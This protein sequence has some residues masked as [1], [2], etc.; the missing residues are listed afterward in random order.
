MLRSLASGFALLLLAPAQ[1][2]AVQSTLPSYTRA[3]QL[4]R[5]ADTSANVSIGDVNND[6]KPDLVL[7]KGRHWP[8][9]S[10]VM[11]GDGRGH[12]PTAYDLS[13][14]RYRS[15]SGNLVDING[16]G[17]LDVILS[18]DAPDPKVILRNDGTG[19]FRSI[20]TF[21]MANWPTRNVAI[22]DLNGD[23]LPDI[24]VANRAQRA[25]EYIC[26]NHQ[27]NFDQPCQPFADYSATT[28]TPADVDGDGRVDLVVPHRDGGQ[29][30][31]YVN[32]GNASFPASRRIPFGPP[33][34]TIR[35]AVVSDLDDDG[36]LDI[37]AIDDTHGATRIYYGLGGGFAAAVPLGDGKSV[38]YAL[39]VTDLNRDRHPDVLVGFVR[40]RSIA[41]FGAGKARTFS[42]VAFGDDRGS[43]YGFASADLD[44]DGCI[45]IAA[46]R[47]EAP[48]MVYF[49]EAV[50]SPPR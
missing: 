22:A 32:D 35:M 25:T 8:G 13:D 16:D 14:T 24:V 45:D 46:A 23:R 43:V 20:S 5:G 15:Y 21:G 12:F 47:S 1:R 4:E 30:Y 49:C 9:M 38:P 36:R 17:A 10:R 19:R 11:L 7:V 31:V 42:P 50:K 26:L 40:S 33:D 18:N 2:G 37:V 44:G 48:N 39:A 6:G 3:L 29:S 41:F 28:I 34:A 27:H